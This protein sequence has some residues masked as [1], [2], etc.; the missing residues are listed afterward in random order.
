MK[1]AIFSAFKTF[2]YQLSIFEDRKEDQED[3]DT[4]FIHCIYGGNF[5]QLEFEIQSIYPSSSFYAVL[6]IV[7][8]VFMI[9]LLQQRS[10]HHRDSFETSTSAPVTSSFLEDYDDDISALTDRSKFISLNISIAQ[11][12]DSSIHEKG[13][14]FFGLI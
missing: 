7:L 2:S 14:S 8:N 5:H 10:R 13:A 1:V 4:L 3:L 12:L 6:F 11:L 9:G